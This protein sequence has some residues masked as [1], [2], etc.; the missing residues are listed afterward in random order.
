MA[1]IRTSRKARFTAALALTGQTLKG[2][3]RKQGMSRYHLSEILTGRRKNA[4][5]VAKCDRFIADVERRF[6]AKVNDAA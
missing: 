3:A 4:D 6:I 5:V 1:R 2:Y